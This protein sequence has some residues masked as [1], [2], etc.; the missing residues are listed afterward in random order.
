[1]GPIRMV[2]PQG[3]PQAGQGG[4]AAVS[5]ALADEAMV[6]FLDA[7][8]QPVGRRRR[9]HVGP[10]PVLEAPTSTGGIARV[11]ATPLIAFRTRLPAGAHSFRLEQPG[12]ATVVAT[13]HATASPF[14]RPPEARKR[15]GNPAAR[16]VLAVLADRFDTPAPFFALCEALL[17]AIRA[18]P[19][20]GE[21]P[22][23]V[24]IEALYW[25]SS[26]AR[27]NFDPLTQASSTDLIYGD[28]ALAARFL[29][30][31][32]VQANRSVVLLNLP[33]RGGAGGTA[34]FP[35]FVTNTDSATDKW[36]DVAIHELGHAL[37]LGDEYDSPNPDAPPGI[38][39]NI[40]ADPDP[41]RAPWRHLVTAPPGIPSAP[42][43]G[44]ANL[45]GKVGTFQGA[46]YEQT[47]FFRPAYRCMMRSTR[48]SFCPRC[49][50]LILAR[51]S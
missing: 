16:F 34:D 35:A 40:C 12:H 14:P 3:A 4:G 19:P 31:S 8:G 50:E 44:G 28:R 26:P 51:L 11:T 47:R 22:D 45:D 7:E 24:A 2:V 43:N 25:N 10:A 18:T 49:R 27:G 30:R 20:F 38:E 1:M 39:P 48:D 23:G 29:R 17:A 9:V 42:Y 6:G 41:A 32:G 37:G 15:F 36:T 33:R 46:R 21:R 5:D 13:I